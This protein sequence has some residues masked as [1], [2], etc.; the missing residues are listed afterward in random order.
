MNMDIIKNNKTS[1]IYSNLTKIFTGTAI[2]QGLSV[3][4]LPIATR[5]YGAEYYGD[6]ALFVA[7]SSIILSFLGFGL[8]SAIM[9][10]DSDE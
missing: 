2:G 5:L 8:S 1:P 10:A 4:F 3:L 6:L 9:T 7:M